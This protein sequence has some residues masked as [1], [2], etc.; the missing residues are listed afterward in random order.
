MLFST[1]ATLFNAFA[2]GLGVYQAQ[3]RG[4]QTYAQ[5]LNGTGL[6]LKPEQFYAV[7]LVCFFVRVFYEF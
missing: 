1:L 5:I 7:D 4:M 6:E 3:Q 2:A